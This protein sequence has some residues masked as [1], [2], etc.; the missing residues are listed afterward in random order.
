M[1]VQDYYSSIKQYTD[2][3]PKSGDWP[4]DV[5]QH[6]ITHLD[7]EIRTQTKKD[8]NYNPALSGK[9]AYT[10]SSNLLEALRHATA[11][12]EQKNF[13]KKYNITAHPGQSSHAR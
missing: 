6:F 9:D 5:C 13:F 1:S 8:F 4:M 3:F 10:Q 11:A 7:E 2:F 12:E